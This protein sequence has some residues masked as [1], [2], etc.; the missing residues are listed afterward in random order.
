MQVAIRRLNRAATQQKRV[1]QARSQVHLSLMQGEPA[2]EEVAEEMGLSSWSLQRRLRE[3]GMSFSSLV[4]NV[5]CG[6]ATPYLQQKP[7]SIS[8]MTRLLGYS[9][10]SAFSRA[11][12]RGFGISPRQ[13]RLQGSDASAAQ[14]Q[15]RR[16]AAN[17]AA[18]EDRSPGR[19]VARR[20]DRAVRRL[21]HA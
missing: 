15:T 21:P 2:L 19:S 20:A 3:E 18:P 4:I 13:W 5:R 16:V 8:A 12:R 6:M 10:V 7:L 9:A 14:I 1:E 17:Q 11:F